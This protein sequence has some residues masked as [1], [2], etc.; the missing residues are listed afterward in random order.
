M[1]GK[2]ELAGEGTVLLDEI[3]DMPWEMQAKL[4]RVLQERTVVRLGGRREVP[5]RARIIATTHRDLDEAVRAGTFRLDL[6]Y[7]LSGVHL[8]LPAL[9]ERRGDIPLLVQH[10]LAR[11]AAREGRPPLVVPPTLMQALIAYDW[12]GNVRELA[13][14]IEGAASLLPADATE[15]VLPPGALER[16]FAV[17]RAGGGSS[18]RQLAT[19]FSEEPIP[20][21]ELEKRAF[22]HALRYFHGNVARAARALGVSRG[23][24]Y[25]KMRLYGFDADATKRD[26]NLARKRGRR[27]ITLETRDVVWHIP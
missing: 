22:E 21:A 11:I 14:L 3:G 19:V 13:H 24:F 8:H 26:Q 7:R 2:L 1:V 20:L 4:L 12:P 17:R 23:T 10:Y 27:A 18:G 16:S 5:I 25:R 15:L 9:R 6:Y